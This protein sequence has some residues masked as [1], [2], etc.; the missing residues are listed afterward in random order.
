MKIGAEI[1]RVM[2]IVIAQNDRMDKADTTYGG[3]FFGLR[4]F[5]GKLQKSEK[6]PFRSIFI[7]TFQ[8]V[9][10][11]ISQRTSIGWIH[12]VIS[13]NFRI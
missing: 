4:W 8:I 10:F 13:H 9:A 12:R 6:W 5:G 3:P 7:A 11:E 2:V 1:L